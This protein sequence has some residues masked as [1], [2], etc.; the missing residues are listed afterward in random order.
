MTKL[1]EKAFDQAA[2]LPAGEQDAFAGFVLADLDRRARYVE[3][4]KDSTRE[5]EAQA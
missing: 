1:L 4:A 2:Q 3:A 5:S